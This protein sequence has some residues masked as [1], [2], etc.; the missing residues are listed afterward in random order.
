MKLGLQNN[1]GR[2]SQRVR[3]GANVNPSPPENSPPTDIALSSQSI[4]ENNSVGDVV[5][6]FSAVDADAGDTFTYDL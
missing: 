4:D 3:L 2:W 1:L 6:A 5:G